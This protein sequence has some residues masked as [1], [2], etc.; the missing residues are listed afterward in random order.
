MA[1]RY[2]NVMLQ[3][4]LKA[5]ARQVYR[6][7]TNATVLR[8]WFCDVATVSPVNGGRIYMAWDDGYYTSGYFL[9]LKECKEVVFTWFGRG[10]PRETRVRLRIKAQKGGS[11]L[12][13][14]HSHIGTGKAWAPIAGEFQKEWEKSLENLASVLETGEDL[15]L[16]RRPM[17]GIGVSDF[18][19]EI[20]RQ[21]GVPVSQGIRLDAVVGGMGAE[22]AG[23]Q[24]GDVIVHMGG[25]DTPDGASLHTVLQAH[26]ADDQVVFE[27]YRGA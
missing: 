20:A 10:E 19:A 6:A 2:Q 11:L 18:D 27:F 23:L 9:I 21:I 16:T 5:D 3:R 15:R 17:M 1:A 24:S 13:L 26:R 14:E 8:E 25:H 4:V 12:T 22:A 7:F